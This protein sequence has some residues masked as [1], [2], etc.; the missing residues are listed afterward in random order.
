MLTHTT[1]I[2]SR[3]GNGQ[4]RN[5]MCSALLTVS[6]Q[7]EVLVAQHAPDPRLPPPV[8]VMPVHDKS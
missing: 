6:A 7:V 2:Y 5:G 8:V 3:Q 1:G 4:D